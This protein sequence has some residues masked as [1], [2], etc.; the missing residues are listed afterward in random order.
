VDRSGGFFGLYMP[1]IGLLRWVR[2]SPFSGGHSNATSELRSGSKLRIEF[3]HRKLRAANN[4]SCRE[5]AGS[6]GAD[7]REWRPS[8]TSKATPAS[9]NQLYARPL[10][11]HISARTGVPTL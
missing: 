3:N 2:H 9:L 4:E 11:E 5:D 8:L 7:R 10:Q 1:A 6:S